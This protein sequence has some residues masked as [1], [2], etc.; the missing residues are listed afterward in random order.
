[1]KISLQSSELKS[2]KLSIEHSTTCGSRTN[3]NRT[4]WLLSQYFQFLLYRY[5]DM[6]CTKRSER[7][8]LNIVYFQRKWIRQG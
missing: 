8:G 3:L 6:P 1:M 2:I 4:I 5:F 7:V